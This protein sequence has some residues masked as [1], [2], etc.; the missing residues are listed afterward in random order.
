LGHTTTYDVPDHLR[1]VSWQDGCNGQLKLVTSKESLNKD[2][3]RNI[4][5][6]KQSTSRTTTEKSADIGSCFKT[7]HK[8]QKDMSVKENHFRNRGL[9]MQIEK[10][11]RER[12]SN[13]QLNLEPFKFNAIVHLVSKTP[14][15][16]S[17]TYTVERIAKGFIRNG[18]IST[19][20]D[21]FP[22]QLTHLFQIY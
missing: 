14:S 9:V 19:T 15:C 11:I 12:M 7:Y 6:C 18:Q 22:Q 10:A 13:N 4:V 21:R 3:K 8:A 20:T 17:E 2:E 1:A 16:Q 5:A